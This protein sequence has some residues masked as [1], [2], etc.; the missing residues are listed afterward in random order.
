MKDAKNILY[1][2]EK[3]SGFSRKEFGSASANYNGSQW[4]VIVF[5]KGKTRKGDKASYRID[6]VH[7]DEAIEL[8][9]LIGGYE[10]KA[11]S[12]VDRMKLQAKKEPV[13]D[14]ENE[15]I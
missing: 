13:K 2:I 12:F 11:I 6:N 9:E 4:N 7:K 15:W 10:E 3:L 14:D 8:V 1:E 5:R